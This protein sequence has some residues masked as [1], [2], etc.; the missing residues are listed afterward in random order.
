MIHVVVFPNHTTTFV[1]YIYLH[2]QECN[3]FQVAQLIKNCTLLT[4]HMHIL[5]F[6]C[7]AKKMKEEE[8]RATLENFVDFSILELRK[9]TSVRRPE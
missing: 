5:L 4:A 8:E 7:V 9:C 1:Q 6:V 3:L 2:R